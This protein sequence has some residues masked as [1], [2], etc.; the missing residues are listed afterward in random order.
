MREGERERWVDLGR[1]SVSCMTIL[2]KMVWCKRGEGKRGRE[3]E[4]EGEGGRGGW[5]WVNDTW[6]Q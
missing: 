6:S 4:K 3:R 5:N 2:F 1:Y